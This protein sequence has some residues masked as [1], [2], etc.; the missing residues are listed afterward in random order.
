MKEHKSQ[1]IY[2][3]VEGAHRIKAKEAAQALITLA[4]YCQSV[5]AFQLN[6]AN[7]HLLEYAQHLGHPLSLIECDVPDVPEEQASDNDVIKFGAYTPR[8]TYTN[9]LSNT[10]CYIFQ[11]ENRYGAYVRRLSEREA[12]KQELYELIQTAKVLDDWFFW[13][14]RDTFKGHLKYLTREEA[15][16]ALERIE[17]LPP[18]YKKEILPPWLRNEKDGCVKN[19]V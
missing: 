16:A 5:G 14:D 11:L 19:F 2:I 18:L 12:G 9:A 13:D 1:N 15:V 7:C 17:N 4:L 10:D 8:Y 6:C 3:E